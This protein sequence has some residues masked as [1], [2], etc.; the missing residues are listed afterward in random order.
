MNVRDKSGRSY[1]LEKELKQG[2]EGAI[3]T[4]K[5]HPDLV[6]KIYHP[7]VKPS[8]AKLRW[9][10]DHPPDDPTAASL[11]HT[12]IAWPRELIY[13][14]KGKFVG[15][16]MPFIAKSVPLLRVFNPKL[17]HQTLPGFDW[18]Y[19]HRTAANLASALSAIHAKN[20]VVGDIN[21]GNFVVRPDALITLLDCDSFQV[22]AQTPKGQQV[23]R[24]P[25]G[26]IEYTPP[27]L[28]G[29]PFA[30]LDRTP[31]HDSF[32][33]GVI[34]FQL[35]MNGNH[36]FRS[37]WRGSGDSPD[38]SEKI[39]RGLFPHQQPPPRQ[40]AP[41]KG[42]PPLDWIHPALQDVMRRCFVD[43][44]KPPHRRPSAEEWEGAIKT[45]EKA[46]I[47]CANGHH[48][49]GHL[50]A[51]P[52]CPQTARGMQ[53]PLPP[54]TPAPTPS[55]RRPTSTPS[56]RPAPIVAP[57][58]LRAPASSWWNR[59]SPR[60]RLAG[61]GGGGL[62]VLLGGYLI[63]GGGG[64]DDGQA[65]S[66]PTA[67]RA[68]TRAAQIVPSATQP[69]A[70][71]TLTPTPTI[72]P[73]ATPDLLAGG[74]W[75]AAQLQPLEGGAT[76]TG[77]PQW[78]F[79]P[80]RVISAS[81]RY[82]ATFQTNRGAFEVELMTRDVPTTANNFVCLARAGYFDDTSFY[83]ITATALQGGDPT[84]TGK[85]GPGYKFADEQIIGDY[86]RG[87]LAM[88]N[89][90]PDTNGSRFFIFTGDYTG[91]KRYPI[92][93]HVVSG[94][95]VLDQIVANPDQPTTIETVTIAEAPA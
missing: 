31:N 83:R 88:V 43:G 16:L 59:L 62:S 80:A 45:A 49:S 42:V 93:G 34:V 27:E 76:G 71:A 25:V 65:F 9:M 18:A 48:Y 30:A 3:W 89:D 81:K 50:T 87:T 17:R 64:G 5:G 57:P 61:I 91:L 85:G 29:K 32:G 94:L 47:Q 39:S 21:E 35:L 67:T 68:A 54:V 51:C 55:P 33:F 10:V 2:G 44:H 8:E 74:C 41:P 78:S 92:F 14:Q 15:F 58:S 7:T 72:V 22:I 26:K 19:L 69:P 40:V 60:Q 4:V 86:V 28:Q 66:A 79:P 38:V 73:T 75:T 1:T 90:G 46:L 95:D 20:Y 24:C 84:G 6:A 11:G 37:D 12:S 70:T 77:S 52:L 36:P 53:S 63:F 56:A 82:T 13:D 23:F